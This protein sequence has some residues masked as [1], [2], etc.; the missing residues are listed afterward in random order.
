MANDTLLISGRMFDEQLFFEGLYFFNVPF[1]PVLSNPEIPSN[2]DFVILS[3]Y[4]N[5]IVSSKTNVVFNLLQDD[6]I[7]LN[8]YDLNGRFIK[9]LLDGN[10]PKGSN[11]VEILLPNL[12]NGVYVLKLFN[13]TTNL[14]RKIVVS[15]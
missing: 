10:Y 7:S 3:N 8:L 4:P 14:Y 5:P 9:K 2:Q 12:M 1:N 13:G 15:N 6:A 11:D